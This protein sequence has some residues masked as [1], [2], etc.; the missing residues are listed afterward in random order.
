MGSKLKIWA[1]A[2]VIGWLLA[3]PVLIV[4]LASPWV[5]FKG[6]PDTRLPENDNRAVAIGQRGGDE[7]SSERA[8]ARRRPAR[9][10]RTPALAAAGTPFTVA[11]VTPDGS[12]RAATVNRRRVAGGRRLSRRPA[13]GRRQAAARTP[14]ATAVPTTAPPAVPA[15]TPVQ[16]ADRGG[17]N[18][19]DGPGLRGPRSRGNDDGGGGVSARGEDDGQSRGNGRGKSRGQG[20][21]AVPGL[22]KGNKQKAREN[23]G[24]AKGKP[25]QG[26]ATDGPPAIPTPGPDS[27]PEAGNRGQGQGGGNP[28]PDKGNRG[29]GHADDLAP[30][31]PAAEQPAE[32]DRGGPPARGGKGPRGRTSSRGRGRR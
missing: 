32:A 20:R 28:G 27:A 7:V 10:V 18:R 29:R 12:T 31:A 21:G 24:R 26:P 1:T 3:V 15:S 2:N 5:V 23:G 4:A 9:P 25:D 19:G 8:N 13:D 30:P 11:V 6:W 14:Q 17:A 22:G 16:V